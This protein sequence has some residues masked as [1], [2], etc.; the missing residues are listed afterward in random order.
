MKTIAKFLGAL[1]I[2]VGLVQ[3]SKYAMN[4]R[5]LTLYGQGFVWGS[6]LLILFGGLLLFWG[7]RKRS[8]KA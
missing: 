3:T 7:F 5:S 1:L 4:Y 8:P 2:L 6:V